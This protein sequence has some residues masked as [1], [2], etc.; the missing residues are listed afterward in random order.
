[1][2]QSYLPRVG[3]HRLSD[4]WQQFSSLE[5]SRRVIHV[6]SSNDYLGLSDSPQVKRAMVEAVQQYGNAPRSSALVAGYT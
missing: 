2:V 4:L 5:E 1:M 6:F 3:R